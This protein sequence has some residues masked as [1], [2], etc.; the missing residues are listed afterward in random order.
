MRRATKA[1][2]AASPNVVKLPTAAPRTVLNNRYAEQRQAMAALREAQP[3]P[4]ERLF[5]GEHEARR[6]AEVLCA[7]EQTPALLMVSALLSVLD[8]DTREKVRKQM[9]SHANS[10]TLAHRQAAVA[11][12]MSFPMTVGERL[13][14][15]RAID[16]V[17]G[18]R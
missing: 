14:L 15:Y 4:G 9:A 18:E 17:T 1:I 10:D 3:W 5:P 2:M 11:T 8:N 12:E 16:Y 13:N 6:M 7:I